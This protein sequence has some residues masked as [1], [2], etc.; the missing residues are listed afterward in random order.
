[1]QTF[2]R[3]VLLGILLMAASACDQMMSDLGVV[4]TPEVTP[5]ISNVS[6]SGEY[7]LTIS[8]VIDEYLPET[9]PAVPEGSKW[10]LIIASV[11]NTTG[12]TITVEENALYLV[13]DKEERYLAEKPDAGTMPPLVGAVI[14]AGQG[15]RGLVRFAIPQDSVPKQLEWC[16]DAECEQRLTIDVPPV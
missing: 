9:T 15:A 8:N 1:M 2:V 5:E 3:M 16:L 11:N 10:I 7:F 4:V 14:P 6:V 12:P 13:D